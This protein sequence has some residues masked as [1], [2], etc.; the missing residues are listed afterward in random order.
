MF[1]QITSCNALNHKTVNIFSELKER[2]KIQFQN[3]L[4]NKRKK[5][6]QQMS[7]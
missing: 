2:K 4:L 5:V 3:D 1:V 7:Y 6:A